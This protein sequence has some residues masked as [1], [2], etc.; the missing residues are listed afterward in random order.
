MKKLFVLF[1]L[2]AGCFAFAAC[3]DDSS[4]D[5][6]PEEPGTEQPGE[7]LPEYWTITI[8][9]QNIIRSDV[10]ESAD[11]AECN[12]CKFEFNAKA[13]IDSVDWGTGNG[14]ESAQE[15]CEKYDDY[16]TLS[17]DTYPR[18]DPD[19]VYSVKIKGHEEL[20]SIESE[21]NMLI[22]NCNFGD[23]AQNMKH[24]SFEPAAVSSFN[25]DEY[26]ILE[27][28]SLWGSSA[29][30][31]QLEFTGS[32]Q[33]LKELRLFV[34]IVDKLDLSN[35]TNLTAFRGSIANTINLS[36]CTSLEIIDFTECKN[37]NLSG[38]SAIKNVDVSGSEIFSLNLEGCTALEELN[39]DRN[40][41][42]KLDLGT[43]VAL[44]EL[45][46]QS[47]QLTTLDVKQCLS[48]TSIACGGNPITDLDL[49]GLSSLK[50]ISCSW[51]GMVS[52]NASN[53]SS[54][55]GESNINNFSNGY[56]LINI[57]SSTLTD[58][59]LDNCTVL[60]HRLFIHGENLKSLSMKNCIGIL[61]LG[62]ENNP[63]LASLNIEG[64]TSL[65]EVECYN[66]NFTGEM[67]NKIFTDLPVE[68]D[69]IIYCDGIGDPSIAE[70]KGW[71]VEVR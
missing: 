23:Y 14:W 30:E 28:L 60:Q 33:L 5:P 35:C 18:T 38:C 54:W 59:I 66:D 48:L 20:N 67:M 62:T 70:E 49:S 3:S 68:E 26:P 52:F 46:C 11:L 6:K 34:Y 51:E 22:V 55:E 56:R 42:S 4:D 24:I 9:V 37:L 19:K 39:C 17:S 1:V 10:W 2:M 25:L 53:C 57:N 63:N 47:N 43:C 7:E 27:Y 41:L 21:D 29:R 61:T 50:K 58:V 36:N 8:D 32:N 16:I 40:N 45:S 44:E 12:K 71:T 69:G 13:V 31:A 15:Y 65:N 64:C